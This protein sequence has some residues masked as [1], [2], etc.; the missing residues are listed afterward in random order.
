MPIT[1]EQVVKLVTSVNDG[2]SKRYAA[3]PI[4]ISFT[5]E[6]RALQKYEETGSAARRAG[7]G[8]PRKTTRRDDRV[9]RLQVLRNRFGTAVET[10]LQEINLKVRRPA[11]GPKLSRGHRTARRNFVATYGQW[12]IPE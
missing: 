6:R 7:S 12:N 5:T 4:G 8:R 9:V 10:R 11:K 1:P 2:R 3:R